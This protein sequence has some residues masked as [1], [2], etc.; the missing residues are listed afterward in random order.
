MRNGWK[1]RLCGIIIIIL[2]F[3]AQ[4]HAALNCQDLMNPPRRVCGSG[5]PSDFIHVA[6]TRN[7]QYQSE[8][9]WAACISMVFQYYGH[10]VRQDRIVTEAYG[11]VVNMPAQPWTLLAMLNREWV[12]DNGNKF[13]CV[14][15]PGSTNTVAAANDLAVNMPLIIGTQGHAVVLTELQYAA[16]Y[17]QTPFGPQLG[18]VSITNAIVRDPWPG[19]GRRSL[20]VMEW[21]NINFAVQIRVSESRNRDDGS[22]NSGLNPGDNATEFC[23]A[24]ITIAKSVSNDFSAIKG[25]KDYQDDEG[26]CSTYVSKVK[27]PDT[28][29]SEIWSCTTSTPRYYFRANAYKGKNEED[30]DKAYSDLCKSIGQ[31][32]S[33]CKLKEKTYDRGISVKAS[34]CSAGAINLYVKMNKFPSTGN[35]NVFL[36]LERATE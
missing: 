29:N 10:P 30:A 14:S 6:A 19:K 5:I 2:G 1:I 28:Q 24:L 20:S 15:T 26:D 36:N 11:S 34:S 13:T 8:W 32:L 27:L 7:P 35:Y 16:L 22:G 17:Q 3:F 9:C 23:N 21:A 18:P 25:K 31:C 33:D 4:G 12:D